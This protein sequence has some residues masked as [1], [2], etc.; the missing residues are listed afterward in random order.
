MA[1]AVR[2]HVRPAGGRR[3]TR[4]YMVKTF[5]ARVLGWTLN[6]FGYVAWL[7]Y[8]VVDDKAGPVRIS[9]ERRN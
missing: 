9:I 4:N 7:R 1:L 8:D 6:P 3:E 5:I 2:E